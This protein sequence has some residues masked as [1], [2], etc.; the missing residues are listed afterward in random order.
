MS[1]IKL[2]AISF[3]FWFSLSCYQSKQS[4]EPTL[5]LISN[6]KVSQPIRITIIGDSLSEWSDGYGLQGSLGERFIVQNLGRAGWDTELW[7]NNLTEPKSIPTDIYFLALGTNDASYRGTLGFATKFNRLIS[8]LNR[9]GIF[10]F[11]ISTTPLTN[12]V[13]LR[14]AI[15][16]NN[17]YLRTLSV[18]QNTWITDVEK[19]LFT[20]DP[21]PFYPLSD[22][23]H[24]SSEGYQLLGKSY[25]SKILTLPLPL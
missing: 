9:T 21:S 15:Q 8:E 2:F 11:L 24:P 25:F 12:Q 19:T 13:G 6:L 17:S 22:P 20:A 14:A 1:P 10:G 4:L 7:L 23:I 18:R 5:G 16:E 3:A